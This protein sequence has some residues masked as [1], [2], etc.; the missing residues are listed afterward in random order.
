[1]KNKLCS[2]FNFNKK[3]LIFN[4]KLYLKYKLYIS[5]GETV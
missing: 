2:Y 5:G 3:I 4:I 1:M